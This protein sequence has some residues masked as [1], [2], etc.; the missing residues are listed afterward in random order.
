MGE[1]GPSKILP[2]QGAEGL[3]LPQGQHRGPLVPI[4]L[5]QAKVLPHDQIGLRVIRGFFQD[6]LGGLD[7]LIGPGQLG[8]FSHPAL[9]Q[10]KQFLFAGLS[11]LCEGQFAELPGGRE[12]VFADGLIQLLQGFLGNGL[13]LGRLLGGGSEFGQR[14]HRHFFGIHLE[15]LGHSVDCLTGGLRIAGLDSDVPGQSQQDELAG[16]LALRFVRLSE[17]LL[18]Q[19]FLVRRG[20]G[21]GIFVAVDLLE[22]LGGFGLGG[23][24]GNRGPA[25]RILGEKGRR[26]QNAK[27]DKRKEVAGRFHGFA[28]VIRVSA[29]ASSDSALSRSHQCS[30]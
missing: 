20:L 25:G 13:V 24:G 21:L 19:G 27:A 7:G 29:S 16:W 4:A 10:G 8:Y 30:P 18:G 12:I 26:G 1:D 2:R 6:E 9:G 23:V 11:S 14:R 3:V 28:P 15:G 5:C 17:Q 22:D